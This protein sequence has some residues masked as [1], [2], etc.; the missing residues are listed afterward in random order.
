MGRANTRN[1]VQVLDFRP[2]ETIDI[3]FNKALVGVDL[4]ITIFLT[5]ASAKV[6]AKN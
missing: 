6:R 3:P 2:K 4:S 5:I 1:V